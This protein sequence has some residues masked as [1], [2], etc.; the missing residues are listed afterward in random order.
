M[1]RPA[2]TLVELLVV[3]AIIAILIALTVPAVQQVRQEAA[4]TECVNHLRQ[5][6][7]ALHGYHERHRQFPQAYNEFFNLCE[8]TDQPTPPDPRPRKSW[9]TLILPFIEQDHLRTMG[10]QQ[11]RQIS[12]NM[13]VCPSDARSHFSST[14]GSYKYLGSKF[15]L[16][17]YLAVEGSLY[18]KGPGNSALNLELGGPKDGVIYRSSTTRVT[19]IRDGSSNT[20]MVGERPPSPPPANDWGWWTWSAYDVALA[21][22]DRRKLPYPSCQANGVYGPGQLDDFCATHHFWSFHRGGAN[23]LFADGSVRFLGYS[24]VQILPKLATRSGGESLDN[25][26]F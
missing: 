22:E 24:A 9:G 19:D 14:G 13:Y 11:Y 7:I 26:S 3:I 18:V 15:G 5:L 17:S 20:V 16:T 21:V 6:G 23:W 12:V 2:F 10:I 25:F 4:R 8:P 1:H